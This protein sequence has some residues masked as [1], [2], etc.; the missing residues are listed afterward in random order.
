M[1]QHQS[2]ETQSN[3][4]SLHRVAGKKGYVSSRGASNLALPM[5]YLADFF[6]CLEDTCDAKT[7][8]KGYIPVAVAENRLVTDILQ[9]RLKTLQTAQAGYTDRDAYSYNSPIGLPVLREA[10]AKILQE[11]FLSPQQQQQQSASTTS[12]INKDHI[13]IGAGAI[14]VLSNLFFALGSPKDAVLIPAPYYAA[15]DNDVR[16]YAG[17][18]AVPVVCDNP[19]KGP[20]PKDLEQARKHAVEKLGLNVRFLLLTH[21]HNPLGVVYEPAVM[22]QAIDW[23]R[24]NKMDTVVDEIYALSVFDDSDSCDFQSILQILDNDL[25][26]DVHMVW[27][28]SKDF[29]ASGFRIGVVY[30]QNELLIEA[31]GNLFTFAWVSQP[32]QFMMADLL[33]D[34]PF[35]D[36]FLAQACQRL[37]HSYELCTRV[38][39]ELEIPFVKAHAAMFVYLDLSELISTVEQEEQ[40]GKVVM[41]RARMVLTPGT[42]QHDPKPG[43]FRICYAYVPADVLEIGMERLRKVVTTIRKQGGLGDWVDDDS[44]WQDIL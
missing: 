22:K 29:G 17:C 44:H 14:S 1:Q 18:V 25:G 19:A 37:K 2:D 39:S 20:S 7:N 36:D 13:G 28:L 41:K 24:S 16:A 40:F 12:T 11:R 32:V 21:P 27:G 26:V 15:F 6:T 42:T 3:G 30:T 5:P 34:K 4:E 33:N 8:P 10:V 23:A 31:L 38:L 35:V 9:T 43:G